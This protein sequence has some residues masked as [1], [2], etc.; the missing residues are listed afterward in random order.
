[1][2][3]TVNRGNAIADTEEITCRPV[4]RDGGLLQVSALYPLQNWLHPTMNMQNIKEK[5]TDRRLSP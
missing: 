3:K 2:E 1:M 4:A 5:H